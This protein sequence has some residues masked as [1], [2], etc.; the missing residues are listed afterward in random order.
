MTGKRP[1]RGAKPGAKPDIV[2]I[3]FGVVA[4][5]LAAPDR[6]DL[7]VRALLREHV[8]KLPETR[9]CPELALFSGFARQVRARRAALGLQDTDADNARLDAA[10]DFAVRVAVALY[11]GTVA[12]VR[13]NSETDRKAAAL[14]ELLRQGVPTLQ[15]FQQLGIPR[16][17]GFRLLSRSDKG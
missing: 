11:G 6:A 9:E 14:G 12:Y 13:K 10:I 17:T 3:L 15:A 4:A 2:D 5:H 1:G 7:G 8:T 16:S